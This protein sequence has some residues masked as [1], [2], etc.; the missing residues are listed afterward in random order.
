MALDFSIEGGLELT[1]GF[2]LRS[3]QDRMVRAWQSAQ[4]RGIRRGLIV[5]ATGTGK[6]TVFSAVIQ[7]MLEDQPGLQVLVLA[8]RQELLD[9]AA[10]RISAMCPELEVA[11]HSGSKRAQAG[12]QVVVA[13]VQSLGNKKSAALD[14]FVPDLVIVDEAHHA[15]ARTYQRIFKRYRC[16]DAKGAYLLGVTATPHRMDNMALHGMSGAIFEE[17]VFK[18]DIVQAIQDGFLVDL[19]GFRAVADY[20]L[21]RVKTVRGDYQQNQLQRE[22]NTEAVNRLAFD[23]WNQVAKDRP[24]I[25]FC[26]GV[27]HAKSVADL[28]NFEGVT[29]A[30]IYG[31]M[32][33]EDRERIL[34]DFRAGRIQVLTN[35]DVLTEGF[36]AQ[37]CSAIL[38]LR[39]TQSW[40]LF[41]QMVGRGLRCLPGLIEGVADA[42]DRRNRLRKSGKPDCIV[43][44]IVGDS[45][46]RE[47]VKVDE[48]KPSLSGLVDLPPG[49]ELEGRT[50]MQAV[51]E[52][53]KM[54]NYMKAAAFRRT[55]TFS[56]LTGV[57]TEVAMIA[58]LDI[59]DE[60][61]SQ[62][63]RL[64]WLKVRD[65]EY[66][67]D[68]GGRGVDQHG[69]QC[70]L[71]RD[72]IGNWTLMLASHHRPAE[73]YPMGRDIEGVF[74]RAE[75]KVKDV[76]FGVTR[77]A[78][79]EAAWRK[80]RPTETQ[81]DYLRL[82]GIGEDVLDALDQ[83]HASALITMMDRSE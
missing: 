50:V 76:F 68:I 64:Y 24:T 39:P 55:M 18:Y 25:V 12:A 71:S 48:E 20:D 8:H 79:R 56:G 58:E 21:S 3:Y 54:P 59:P 49:L 73:S 23:S 80:G 42:I 16:F 5:A 43:I 38:L 40:S 36:D 78:A 67:L 10:E 7:S 37:H 44:D 69:R 46:G 14:W 33:R 32:K 30:A 31:E 17:L 57:L 53:S 13:S 4:D 15:A 34:G 63:T 2:Q 11:I 19:R 41:A 62:D 35:M 61:A 81:L 45:A 75:R 77:L 65:G 9:Q 72:M 22:L 6:T 66:L 29:A 27:E 52:F 83:G 70:V 1:G 82:K 26:S 51:D 74:E 60:A 28:F 47:T